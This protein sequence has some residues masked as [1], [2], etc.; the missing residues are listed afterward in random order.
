ML[1]LDFGFWILDFTSKAGRFLARQGVDSTAE[2]GRKE[3]RVAAMREMFCPWGVVDVAVALAAFLATTVTVALVLSPWMPREGSP[4]LWFGPTVTSVGGA[5]AAGVILILLRRRYGL[6]PRDVGLKLWPRPMDLAIAIA[7]MA[8]VVA[9]WMPMG[10]FF[11][12]LRERANAPKELQKV[13]Q[14]VRTAQESQDLLSLIVMAGSAL[15]VAPFWEELA[16]RGFLQPWLR[17]LLGPAGGIVVTTVL[18]SAIHEP[19]SRFARVP[20]MMFP[21]ALALSYARERTGRLTPCILLHVLN[22]ALTVAV[23]LAGT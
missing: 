15:F 10:S 22:N 1:I 23:V 12:W 16:F 3:R 2:S 5:A 21:L 20:V 9:V 4:R 11:D 8:A 7:L 6:W 13:V 14:Q 19:L 18:F 17:G